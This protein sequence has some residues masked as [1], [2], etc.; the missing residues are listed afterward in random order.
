M[1]TE[2][3]WVP[4]VIALIGA[5]V[6]QYNTSQTNK[7]R[8]AEI[9]QGIRKTSEE[10]KQADRKINE[11]L[12]KTAK[13]NVLPFKQDLQ[14]QFM[15]TIQK[16][17]LQGLAGLDTSGSTSS[18][19]KT[20]ADQAKTGATDYAGTIASLLAGVDAAGN[21][22]QA[23]G[24]SAGNLGMDLMRSDR[25]QEQDTFL[26]QLRA[27]RHR[28]NPWLAMAGSGLS[29]YASGMGGGK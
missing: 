6:Q 28:D 17:R 1:G 9:A 14:Q 20:G 21:Q 29:G 10:Q 15:D 19:Y 2:A 5:G 25:N 3:A 8:D 4:A 16:K 22:R 27:A 26:A 11:N 7:K 24:T 13:S 18:A 23:E 12:D